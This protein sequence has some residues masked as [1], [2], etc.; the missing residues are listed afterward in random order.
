MPIESDPLPLESRREE[1]PAFRIT[2]PMA[3]AMIGLCLSVVAVPIYAALILIPPAVPR[4]QWYERFAAGFGFA[5][6]ASLA[7]VCIALM[8]RRPWS[9][10]GMVAWS[11][12]MLA[13]QC[14]NFVIAMTLYVP[15]RRSILTTALTQQTAAATQPTSRP[16]YFD[17]FAN[18][19][20]WVMPVITFLA[21]GGYAWWVLRVMRRE[22]GH[23][24]V[25]Q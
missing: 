19:G 8:R 16:A 21:L 6:M 2:P 14:I 11:M 17:A 5:A 10:R 1:A 4:L 24:G 12:A 7:V 13:W 15:A 25:I 9:R 18:F 3:V 22:Q 20:I 23:G